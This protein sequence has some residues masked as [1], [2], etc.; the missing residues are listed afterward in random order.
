MSDLRA[1][2]A[3]GGTIA[4]VAIIVGIFSLIQTTPTISETSTYG[5]YGHVTIKILNSD[6]TIKAY[7]Q[8]DN[9]ALDQFKNCALDL[10]VGSSLAFS[11]C[12][13]I[14][15]MVIGDTGD[16]LIPLN[17][18]A[19]AMSNEYTATSFR[20]PVLVS[21]SSATSTSTDDSASIT[22]RVSVSTT[23]EFIISATD[24]NG[25]A[26]P[27]CGDTDGDAVN[28]CD[29]DEVGL[30]DSSGTFYAR[31]SFNPSEVTAGDIVE[32]DYTITV[33]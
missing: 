4:S 29:I 23:N 25:S 11:T 24:V 3:I 10:N 13:T 9:A 21:G 1:I 20:T 7:V 15:Q 5:I 32:M 12:A 14:N 2:V 26:D 6:G 31:T 27:S 8:T 17:D 18:D 30:K 22:L 19:L 33:G 28:E 16:S